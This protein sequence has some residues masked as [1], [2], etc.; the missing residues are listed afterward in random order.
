MNFIKK[1][2]L[3]VLSFLLFAINLQAQNALIDSLKNEL[4]NHLQ[5][6]STR[7][8]LLN[9]IA[10]KNYGRDQ[11]QLK[12][13]ADEANALAIKIGFVKGE[14]KSWYFRAL[15]YLTKRDL[16]N[17]LAS[18]NKSLSLEEKRG[19]K[20]G[21][22]RCYNTTGTI[23]RFEEDFE[24]SILFYDKAFKIEREIGNQI[25]A[26]GILSNIG[27][28][29]NTQGEFDEAE[30]VLKESIAISDSLNEKKKALNSIANLAL[31]YNQQG[32]HTEALGYYQRCLTGYRESGDKIFGAGLLINMSLVY[33]SIDEVDKALPFLEESLELSKE[34]G[35]DLYVSMALNGLGYVHRF[36]KEYDKALEYYNEGLAICKKINSN[37]GLQN[38]YTSL[39][40]LHLEKEEFNLALERFKEAL[41]VSEALGSKTGIAGSH[42]ELGVIYYKL[43]N[44]EE[45]FRKITQL[46]YEYKYKKELED[47]SLRESKL[48][49]TVNTTTQNLEK[50]QRNLLLGVIAFLLMTLILSA[51]IFFLKLRNAKAE[52]QNIITEQKLL[53]SQMTPHFVFNSLSVLQGMILNNEKKKSI[54]YLSKFSKLLRITLENSREKTVPL[55]QELTAINNYLE[56]QNLE[57]NEPYQYNISVDNNI[58][59]ASFEIPP[60]LI[61]PFIENAIEHGFKNKKENKKIDV[62]L[63]YSNK[64]LSCKIIDNGIGIDTQKENEKQDKKSLATTITSERLKILSD[65]FQVEGAINIEDRN[66]YNEQGTIVTLV[67]PYK[68]NTAQ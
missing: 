27:A 22:A 23:F 58:E 45:S 4:A 35:N 18:I 66:K 37:L 15:Y 56:L 25:K 1:S 29:R 59:T 32:R 68:V 61:Q 57:V 9:A 36:K 12:E 8:N 54:S 24:K 26:A 50:S 39:G 60:M 62:E 28:V 49:E 2:I 44:Y 40:M 10:N 6:D 38:C 7:V 20:A 67:V 11:D 30:R 65:D 48:T 16:E 52:A 13:Y 17:A 41:E 3:P 14:A 43:G 46:E 53:R 5:E 64:E 47:A 34:I 63:K 19:S 33:S 55:Q 21:I 31:V 51:I 42:T